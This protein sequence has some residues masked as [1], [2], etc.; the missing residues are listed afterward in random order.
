MNGAE[1]VSKRLAKFPKGLEYSH[2]LYCPT[3]S[4][5]NWLAKHVQDLMQISETIELGRSCKGVGC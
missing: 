3:S 2:L 5:A 1:Y 4:K